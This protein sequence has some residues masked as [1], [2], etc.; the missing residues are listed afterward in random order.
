VPIKA[1]L[2]KTIVNWRAQQCGGEIKLVER[3]DGSPILM[4]TFH[5]HADRSPSDMV[6]VANSGFG[7]IWPGA[8]PGVLGEVAKANGADLVRFYHPETL[9]PHKLR[10]DRMVRDVVDVVAAQAEEAKI[11]LVGASFGAAENMYAADC[12]N[13]VTPGR[14][15]GQAGWAMVPPVALLNLLKSQKGYKAFELGETDR[16]KIVSP[17][18]AKP[19]V[20]SCEQR[21]SV[22]LYTPDQRGP[23]Q[24]FNGAACFAAGIQDTVGHPSYTRAMLEQLYP[25]QPA[26]VN[27]SIKELNCGHKIPTNDIAQSVQQVMRK[28]GR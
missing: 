16:L 23:L 27:A 2:L 5:A 26:V 21:V 13:A 18:L 7:A 4:Q 9:E 8:N 19:F 22:S 1:S 17:T 14:V 6:M 25:K 10:Y 20:M 24:P 3:Y 15:V 12:I 11:V 28:L